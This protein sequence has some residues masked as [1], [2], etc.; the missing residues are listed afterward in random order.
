MNKKLLFSLSIIP[1][2]LTGCSMNRP[3][4]SDGHGLHWNTY[5]TYQEMMDAQKELQNKDPGTTKTR[6]FLSF[7]IDPIEDFSV[8]YQILGVCWCGRNKQHDKHGI[9]PN[10]RHG[11]LYCKCLK[12]SESL[13]IK[14]CEVNNID[15]N[16]FKNTK[17]LKKMDSEHYVL[18]NESGDYL[19][20]LWFTSTNL[21]NEYGEYFFKQIENALNILNKR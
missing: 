1:L 11:N 3:N 6:Y 14:Y 4:D 19:I 10:L 7:Q 20:E 12:D 17:W 16:L 2:V 13:T 21:Y 5:N 9:C 15:E 18:F 8:E